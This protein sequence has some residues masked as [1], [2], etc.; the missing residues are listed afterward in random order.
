LAYS[1]GLQI[2]L[3]PYLINSGWFIRQFEKLEAIYSKIIEKRIN[4]RT[5]S[6]KKG[7]FYVV[8]RP[9]VGALPPERDG[10]GASPVLYHM[11]AP[12]LYKLWR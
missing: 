3:V 2:L 9:D 8:D 12:D 11:G 7:D 1:I 4:S 10:E 6:R 5:C